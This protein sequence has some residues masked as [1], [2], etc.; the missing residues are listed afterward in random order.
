MQDKYLIV[1][2]HDATP[3]FKSEISDIIFELDRIGL[4]TRN[5]G[6]VPNFENKYDI[7]KDD[8]FAS[9]LLEHNNNGTEI[10]LHGYTH[11]SEHR[12][13]NQPIE[14]FKGEIFAKGEAEFQNTSY[15]E[16]LDKINRGKEIFNRIGLK[17]EGFIPPCWLVNPQSLQAIKNSEFEYLVT[18][19]RVT[20]LTSQKDFLSK[21]C[22]FSS[23]N[24]PM[25]IASQTY[26][27]YL[28]NIHLVNNKL[29]TLPIHPRNIWEEKSF[30]HFL[31]A[32]KRN[33][34]KG[35][36]P[37]NYHQFLESLK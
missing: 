9:W 2:V 4:K 12:T 20:A 18:A 6:I 34:K 36:K 25:S 32:I 13:Y 24:L 15:E 26:D 28:E 33:V 8:A 19:G 27:W 3:K 23:C 1:S 37:T 16:S 30:N 5:I 17:Y 14:W 29:L 11:Q 31:T 7:S 22:F 35:R 10:F 21:V